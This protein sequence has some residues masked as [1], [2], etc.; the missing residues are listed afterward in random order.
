M[1][2]LKLDEFFGYKFLSEL[3][4]SP[5]GK[6]A[7]VVVQEADAEENGYK[8]AIWLYKNGEWLKL[9]GLDKEKGYVW[10]DDT[11]ILFPASR[12]K[13]EQKRH[14]AGEEFTSYYRISTNGGEASFAFELPFGGS[15]KEKFLG[16]WLVFGS[17]DVNHPD[18]YKLTKEERETVAKET[19]EN[20]DYEVLDEI[21]FYSNGGGFTNGSRDTIFVFDEKENKTERI[22]EN[23]FACGGYTKLNGKLYFSGGISKDV[24]YTLNDDIYEYDLEKATLRK[25][26]TNGTG[27]SVYFVCNIDGKLIVCGE[28]VSEYRISDEPK[29]Y[30]LDVETGKLDIFCDNMFT[31]MNSTGSDC[32]LGS[33]RQVLEKNNA[34]YIL[35]TER[36]DGILRK[37]DKDGNISVVYSQSGSIDDFDINDNGDIIANCMYGG[38]LAEIYMLTDKAE[39]ISS[40]NDAILEGKYVAEYNKL[41]INSEGWDIDGWVLLPKD[42]DENKKYP[43]ILDIHGGPRTVFGEI[44]FHEMQYWAGQGYFV[45]FCNPVGG[46]GRG[47]KFADITDRYGS[48]DFKNIM[49]FTDA[50]L[51]K[52]PQIDKNRV[53]CTGGSYGGYMSNWILGHTDRFAAVATQRSISNWISFYGVSDIGY[54][55]CKNQHGNDIYS[56]KGLERLWDVSPLKYINNMKTPTLFIH[57]NED[58]RCPLEQ[59]LQLFTAMKEKGIPVRMC[60]FKGENHEL[61]RSGKPLHRKRRLVEITNWMDKYLK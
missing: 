24:L 59:G 61:S 51:E 14:E 55:F 5:D 4:Y 37:L 7:A 56:E 33:K 26:T 13:E 60:M 35:A 21:P 17:Y 16:K 25:V 1:E 27:L 50:V 31:L 2:A 38:K 39:K 58:Y 30:A 43:A 47:Q 10:E 42:F 15:I 36:N 52:Y 49:D 48:I 46:S 6:Q 34:L 11:H 20:E 53:G 44:F 40:F 18:Y 9:T 19:K 57:S 41:T 12:T 29:F 23:F 8:S 3:K 32:R 45:F 28:P 22:G 54:F